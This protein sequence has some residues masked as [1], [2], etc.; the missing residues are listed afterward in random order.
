MQ[1][2]NDSVFGQWWSDF[3]A[4]YYW[5]Y[6]ITDS[7]IEAIMTGKWFFMLVLM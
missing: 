5:D 7:E 3:I 1:C 4:Y 6:K 2:L